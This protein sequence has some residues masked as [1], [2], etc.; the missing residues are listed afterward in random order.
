MRKIISLSSNFLKHLLLLCLLSSAVANAATI[1]F[2]SN[3]GSDVN[4][5]AQTNTSYETPGPFDPAIPPIDI[6]SASNRDFFQLSGFDSA[7][8]T[9]LAVEITYTI[10]TNIRTS[11][12][13]IGFVCD[14]L[15]LICGEPQWDAAINNTIT[16][17]L[18]LYSPNYG[19][20]IANTYSLIHSCDEGGCANGAMGGTIS[21]V[22]M[23]SGNFFSSADPST[24][25]NFIDRSL[26]FSYAASLSSTLTCSVNADCSNDFVSRIYGQAT[27][28]YTY[29]EVAPVPVPASAW[30][31]GAALL[32]LFG[33]KRK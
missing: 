21:D 29:D 26:N 16:T 28:K 5:F 9:L 13:G 10:T 22:N 32:G 14:P 4:A 17:E 1:N 6:E 23:A 19:P 33:W 18:D 11:L 31:F 15:G 2:S 25:S 30:L 3:F 12:Q 7:L 8:G 20:T 24:L 27:V